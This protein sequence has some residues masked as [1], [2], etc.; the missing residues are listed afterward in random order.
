MLLL[1]K[2]EENALKTKENRKRKISEKPQSGK[3][4][5][6]QQLGMGEYI[7]KTLRNSDA[8]SRNFS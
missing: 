8:K 1:G 2:R 7:L 3:W 6:P 5:L 4:I